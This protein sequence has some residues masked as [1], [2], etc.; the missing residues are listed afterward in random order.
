MRTALDLTAEWNKLDNSGVLTMG[1]IVVRTAFAQEHP[2]A[3]DA[4]LQ[5][6]GK[7]IEAV[8][9]DVDTAAQLC[10]TYGIV[11]KAAVAKKA[12][13]DCNL[14]FV[15]GAEIQSAIEPYYNVLFA[16]NPASIGGA[17]PGSDFYYVSAASSNG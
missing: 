15:S 5:E 11:A 13:P 8:Q 3:V 16:A 14:C 4:F 6:Y 12:I 17:M 1:C 2:E 9:S 7:S 10:E